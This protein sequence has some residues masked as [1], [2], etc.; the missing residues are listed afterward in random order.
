MVD[1][2]LP[3]DSEVALA[4]AVSA[5]AGPEEAGSGGISHRRNTFLGNR[6]KQVDRSAESD[7]V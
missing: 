1:S 3:E 4:A 7:V 2:V 6:P 5:A